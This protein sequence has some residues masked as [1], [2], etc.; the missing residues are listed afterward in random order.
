MRLSILRRIM[1]I[2]EGVIGQGDNPSE[3]SI[4]SSYD[5]KAKFNNIV[6]LFYHSLKMILCLKT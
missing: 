1:E 6:L 5:M 2:E 3:I 4:Y